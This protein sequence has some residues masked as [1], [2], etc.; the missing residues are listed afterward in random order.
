MA[1]R[2]QIRRGTAAEWTLA[3]PRLG[4]GE[5]GIESD[6]NRMKIGNGSDLWTT[7]PY[8]DAVIA[9]AVVGSG[10]VVDAMASNQTVID[11]AVTAVDGAVADPAFPSTL[12]PV[13]TPL[14]AAALAADDA[15]AA[16]AAIAASDAVDAEIAGRDL[17]EYADA[18]N[19]ID[20]VGGLLLAD[21]QVTAFVHGADG[22]P[23]PSANALLAEGME[24]DGYVV[25]REIVT[26]VED[27][28][29]E[30]W[31]SPAA[32]YQSAPYPRTVVGGIDQDS[33][34]IVAEYIHGTGQTRRYVL[35]RAPGPMGND[36]HNPPSVWVKDGHRTLAAWTWHNGNSNLYFR[37]GS[38]SGD[39][40]SLQEAT[41]VVVSNG[42]NAASYTD[43]HRIEYLS[44]ATQDTFWVFTRRDNHTR[45]ILPVSINQATGALTA[46]AFI[47][48]LQT[49][50]GSGQLY[51]STADAYA[52][53]DQVIRFAT[54]RHPNNGSAASGVHYLEINC[55]TGAITS[56]YHAITANISG[57]GLPLLTGSITPMVAPVVGSI[58]WIYATRSGPDYRAVLYGEWPEADN[59]AGTYYIAEDS[60]SG[61]VVTDLGPMGPAFGFAGTSNLSYF[62]GV[63]FE[64]PSYD[65]IVYRAASDGTTDTLT[66]IRMNADPPVEDVLLSQPSSAGR[67]VRPRSPIG[68]GP[69]RVIVTDM[70][71][72]APDNYTDYLGDL[73][74]VS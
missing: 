46:S 62:A 49:T 67:L 60:G 50:G 25:S 9:D 40:A 66:R 41:T 24:R 54:C 37:V 31:V 72:Y 3:N 34:V 32:T 36:D 33:Y 10:A 35:E 57:A 61:V 26:T 68:G 42:S 5:Q 74:G 51:G 17:A 13:V 6:T 52:S 14:V 71:E 73:K 12:E 29:F 23:I 22:V 27:A 8:Y 16:A 15:P 48:I 53:G 55:V 20:A 70:R 1:V 38:A 39:L 59:T 69:F 21:G 4:P 56:P 19:A 7:L 28:V 43:I 44:D 30:W 2:I 64:Y 58:R 45:G 18:D 47:P 63:D 11:A 65:R